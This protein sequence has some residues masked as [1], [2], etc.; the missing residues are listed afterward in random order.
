[1]KINILDQNIKRAD[2]LQHQ[3]DHQ[4]EMWEKLKDLIFE[5]RTL[6]EPIDKNYK[7]EDGAKCVVLKMLEKKMQEL[8]GEKDVK[9]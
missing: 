9:D 3:L 2:D 8:E 7:S 1:M 4:K 6:Y 5:L